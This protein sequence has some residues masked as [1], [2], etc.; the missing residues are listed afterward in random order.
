MFSEAE[1]PPTLEWGPDFF[2]GGG[3]FILDKTD[4]VGEDLIEELDLIKASSNTH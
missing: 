4:R 1:L 3:C 2:L